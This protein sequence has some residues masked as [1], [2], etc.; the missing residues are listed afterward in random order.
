[1]PAGLRRPG[2]HGLRLL[3]R[4]EGDLV[5]IM[6]DDLAANHIFSLSSDRLPRRQ[7]DTAVTVLL[8][9]E[10][11][12]NRSLA[13]DGLKKGRYRLDSQLI[14]ALLET[15]NKQA[16]WAIVQSPTALACLQIGRAH[17]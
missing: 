6:A 16:Q 13:Y 10:S 15:A 5:Q 14:V 8:L 11:V 12:P 1:M 9:L 7:L 17:V 4:Q 2:I 3:G